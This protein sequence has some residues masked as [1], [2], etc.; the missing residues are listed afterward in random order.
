MPVSEYSWKLS[1]IT[2]I[3]MGSAMHEDYLIVLGNYVNLNGKCTLKYLSHN[4]V[5]ELLLD[6]QCDKLLINASEFSRKQ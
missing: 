3:K 2:F 4:Y 1:V 6:H 5:H